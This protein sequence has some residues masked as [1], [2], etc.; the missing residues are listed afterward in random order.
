MKR[1]AEKSKNCVDDL[2]LA[3]IP[4]LRK[5]GRDSG[6]RSYALSQCKRLSQREID[7]DAMTK[8]KGGAGTGAQ[9]QAGSGSGKA[10]AGSGNGS[11]SKGKMEKKNVVR[12]QRSRNDEAVHEQLREAISAV[13]KPDRRAAV[14]RDVLEEAERRGGGKGRGRTAVGQRVTKGKL[15]HISYFI[16]MFFILCSILQY[17]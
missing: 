2:S 7:F 6:S 15:S 4:A 14:G 17:V 13:K 12:P 10:P 16:S 5:K 3:A 1:E 11:D 9:M 8:V